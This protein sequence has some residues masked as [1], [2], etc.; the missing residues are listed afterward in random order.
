MILI[1]RARSLV[2]WCDAQWSKIRMRGSRGKI[3]GRKIGN[4]GQTEGNKQLIRAYGS[5]K[6]VHVVDAGHAKTPVVVSRVRR[7]RAPRLPWRLSPFTSTEVVYG[8]TG[9]D[10]TVLPE[11]GVSP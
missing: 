4:S 7:D 6:V 3:G 9:S 5:G 11:Y 8:V 2:H 10:V 1:D